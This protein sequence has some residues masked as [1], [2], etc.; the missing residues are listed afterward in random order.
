MKRSILT[1][2]LS[3]FLLLLFSVAQAESVLF[4]SIV[5][6]DGATY[7]ADLI[8]EPESVLADGQSQ[9][10]VLILLRNKQNEPV[11]NKTISLTTSRPDKD[12]IEE[13]SSQTGVNGV[14]YFKLKSQFAGTSIIS[15]SLNNV[16]IG[17][18]QL[19][20]FRKSL[21]FSMMNNPILVAASFFVA[22]ELLRWLW[23]TLFNRRRSKPAGK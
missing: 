17:E 23:L 11:A 9:A 16:E 3:L 13:T 1:L 19:I 6:T 2:S 4:T 14:A 15:A 21:V 10:V 7:S 12:D 22:L 18:G 5:D 8:I 20:F